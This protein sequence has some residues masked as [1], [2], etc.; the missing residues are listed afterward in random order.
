MSKPSIAQ[1]F[2]SESGQTLDVGRRKGARRSTLLL[3]VSLASFYRL[4][5]SNEVTGMW[6]C[7]QRPPSVASLAE[8]AHAFVFDSATAAMSTATDNFEAWVPRWQSSFPNGELDEPSCKGKLVLN[9]NR[10]T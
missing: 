8:G 3:G 9:K 10:P 6:S 5:G 1:R 2:A 7:G 4:P